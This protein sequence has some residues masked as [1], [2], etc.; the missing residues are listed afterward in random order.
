[1][2]AK[3]AEG[4][5]RRR[6][7]HG[8]TLAGTA[9]VLGLHARP[10][11]AE[12]AP[13]MTTL[14][15]VQTA[16]SCQAPQ[17]IAGELLRAEGFTQVHYVRKPGGKELEA[18]LSSGEVNIN[19]HYGA[20]TLIR[21]DAGDPLVILAGGHIGC[22]ELIGSK[23]VRAIRDRN[24]KTIAVV[25]LGDPGHLFIA[26]MAAYMGLEPQK[27][28]IWGTHPAAEAVRLLTEGK[29]DAFLPFPPHR[30]K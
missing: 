26:S 18:A 4:W 10:V 13:E 30:R 12:P 9:G 22:F 29:V 7:L 15:L 24:G 25:D 8:L 2:R 14:T 1:M 21:L 16:S 19:M 17:Y 3:R 23:R 6:F 27:D 20:A 5:S 11:A 28:I